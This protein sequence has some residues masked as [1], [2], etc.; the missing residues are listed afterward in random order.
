MLYDCGL[1]RLTTTKTSASTKAKPLLQLFYASVV[2]SLVMS[3]RLGTC[4]LNHKADLL[5]PLSH[6]R[7]QAVMSALHSILLHPL[8]GRGIMLGPVLEVDLSNL[9]HQWVIGVWV[10][11]KR[12]DG[13]QDLGDCQ[14][15]APL[16]LQDV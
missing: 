11:Q 9:W 8:T 14:S 4:V 12:R 6:S 7:I 2:V 5:P 1:V 13:E 16:I 3:I 15:W 10:C